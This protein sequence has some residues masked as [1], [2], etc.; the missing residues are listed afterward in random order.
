MSNAQATRIDDC[1]E[2]ANVAVTLILKTKGVTLLGPG[3]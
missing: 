3:T 1:A 2:N